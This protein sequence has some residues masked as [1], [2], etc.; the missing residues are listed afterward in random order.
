MVMAVAA[1][2][3]GAMVM[4]VAAT[5]GAATATTAATEKEEEDQCP[6]CK[7]ELA[8]EPVYTLDCQGKH[9]FH[10]KCIYKSVVT[11][12]GRRLCPCCSTPF[13]VIGLKTALRGID[14]DQTDAGLQGAIHQSL[15]D[16]QG[17]LNGA[18]TS[19]VNPP[20]ELDESSPSSSTSG[21]V[22]DDYHPGGVKVKPGKGKER[23]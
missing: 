9:T 15:A 10:C 13:S 17:A 23:M 14:F 22:D 20:I 12:R 21:D 16:Q 3:V 2:A 5:A 11:Y 4:A 19:N 1:T 18:G 8:E 7:E 6:I